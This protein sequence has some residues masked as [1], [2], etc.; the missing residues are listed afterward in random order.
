MS[1]TTPA[2][3]PSPIVELAGLALTLS[4]GAGE[5][6]I[7][8]GIDV[9]IAAGEQVALVGASGAGKS[10]MM[11][12]IG[13][14]ERATSGAVRV[15][16]YDLTAMSEDELALFRRGHV[17][18]VFQSFHLVPTMTALENVAVPLEFAGHADAFGLA[19]KELEAVGLG[20]RLEHYPGPAF[21]RRT[22]ARGAGAR[23]R[24]RA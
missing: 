9:D 2:A 5:V 1:L 22:A 4:S 8:R 21:G 18:I 17:G 10:S 7:L 23:L 3:A 12:I 6:H 20:H 14:L 11:M 16:G 13:G 15:A 24:H 19:Q